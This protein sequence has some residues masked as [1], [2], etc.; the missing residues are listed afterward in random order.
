[1]QRLYADLLRLRRAD[2]VLAQQDRFL[3]DAWA[4][5]PDL[6]VVAWRHP[7]TPRL[8]LA[9]F[10]AATQL[11]RSALRTSLPPGAGR[12][13]LDTAARDYGGRG[14]RSTVTATALS[15]PAH[16]ALLLAWD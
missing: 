7:R 1:M 3:L 10:G 13:L 9:N 15:L 6:L 14:A 16:T 11:H 8:L 4:A 5:T 2:P 12:V